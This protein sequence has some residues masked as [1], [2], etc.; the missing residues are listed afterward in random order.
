LPELGDD[1]AG[2]Q[3]DRGSEEAER[4]AAAPTP[5]LAA[6]QREHERE[7]AA[8]EEDETGPVEPAVVLV[9]RLVEVRHRTGDARDADRHVDEEDPPPPAHSVSAPT[10]VDRN[11]PRRSS[12]SDPEGGPALA[13]S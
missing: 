4:P 2:E 6:E 9:S 7:E 10:R 3:H 11:R 13:P 12:P 5:A 1:E 8:C